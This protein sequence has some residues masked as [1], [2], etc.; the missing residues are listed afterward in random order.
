[1]LELV[2]FEEL[3]AVLR[4]QKEDLEDYPDLA[5]IISSVYAAIES[6]TWRTLEYSDE[7]VE[8]IWF[9]GRIVSLKALPIIDLASVVL[10]GMEVQSLAKIRQDGIEFLSP[11]RGRAEVTY[12]GGYETAPP[13]LKRAATLQVLHEFQRKDKVGAESVS[14]EGGFTRWPQMGLLDEVKRLLAPFVH[15]ARLI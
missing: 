11:M 15:P 10:D 3:R 2:D 12:E 5:A 9:D 8:T 13:A 1:M 14:N 4:L 6:H 7:H